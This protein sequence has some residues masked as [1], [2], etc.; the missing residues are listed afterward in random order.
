MKRLL[1]AVSALAIFP[2]LSFAAI[3]VRYQ[4]APPAL[5]I[6][7]AIDTQ[8]QAAFG[9]EPLREIKVRPV[10]SS[11]PAY[12][13]VRLHSAKY[14]KFESV[15]I[16]LNGKA[17][18]TNVVRR[19]HLQAQDRLDANTQVQCPDEA[20]EFISFAPNDDDFEQDIARQVDSA[21]K[22]KGLKTV[23]LLGED[24][25]R[26][27][28]LNYMS[29]PNLK[30]NFYDGDSNPEEMITVDDSITA[31]DYKT[32]LLEKF[33]FKVTNI[34]LACQAFND[35]M[36]TAV[37]VGA[38]SQKYAAGINDLQ[39][40]PSDKA[41]ACAMEAAFEGKPMT[42]SFQECYKKFDNEDDHWGFD[43]LGSDFFGK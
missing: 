8:L 18:F 41:A 27:A 3:P 29:C 26:K 40:G 22:T 30:G 4:N 37:T 35:P 10:L 33:R 36:L 28:Y 34:W 38:Q 42:A 24:A 13:I 19:Y 39:V 5:A 23:L 9:T 31:D 1:L 43:G 16:E 7:K 32:I 6:Q 25:T 14:H 2:Q 12:L 20:I 17:Q 11:G 15:K 21:A